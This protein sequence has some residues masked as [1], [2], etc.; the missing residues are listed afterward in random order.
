MTKSS[1]LQ[2]Y[3]GCAGWNIPA[4]EAASFPESGTHLQ[5]YAAVFSAVEINSSFYRP[6]R[7]ATYARWR[8]SVPSSFRFSVKMPRELTH[9]RRLRHAAEPMQRFLDEVRHLKEKLGCLLLQL[10]PS[11]NFS[12]AEVDAFLEQL[13]QRFDGPVVCEPR[14]PTWGSD[15]AS[16]LLEAWSI[17]RVIAD[18]EPVPVTLNPDARIAY[19]R[20]HGS[21]EMYASSYSDAFLASLAARL[22]EHMTMKRDIWCVFDNTMY[23]AATC[24]ALVLRDF[25]SDWFRHASSRRSR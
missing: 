18:P 1:S 12:H 5:R 25:F 16:T 6:H 14:H 7:P 21:P 3:I 24:N 9:V 20:L 15:E 23:G 22:E 4:A 8:D 13:R 10:P 11:L 19:F 2:P 17:T